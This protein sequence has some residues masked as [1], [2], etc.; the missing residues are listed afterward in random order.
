MHISPEGMRV[1]HTVCGAHY[2]QQPTLTCSVWSQQGAHG[3]DWASSSAGRAR[4]SQPQHRTAWFD[5]GSSLALEVE[6][7]S[8]VLSTTRETGKKPAHLQANSEGACW[9]ASAVAVI[10]S[11]CS[12][13]FRTALNIF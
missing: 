12:C 13:A 9:H 3:Q 4:Q 11:L 10:H 1:M 7:L 6:V 8:T 5:C 2:D